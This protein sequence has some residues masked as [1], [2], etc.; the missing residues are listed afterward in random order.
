MP[1]EIIGHMQSYE[2]GKLGKESLV[3]QIMCKNSDFKINDQTPYAE[4]WMGIHNNG[5]SIVKD[6]EQPLSTWLKKYVNAEKSTIEQL[7]PFLFKVLSVNKAL[8]IQCHPNKQQAM[9]LFKKMPTIYKDGNHK[10][11]MTIAVTEFQVMSGFRPVDEI[12]TFLKEIPE[13]EMLFPKGLI[14]NYLN[15]HKEEYMKEI[16]K[17]WLAKKESEMEPIIKS[18]LNR[19]GNKDDDVK[20]KYHFSLIKQLSEWYPNDVGVF[21]PFFLN[22]F[23]L[24][25]GECMFIA[26]G[27]PHAYI[28]G[29][30]VECMACSDNV[31][32]CGLTP[33]LKDV[34][35]LLEILDFKSYTV[36][37]LKM[38]GVPKGTGNVMVFNPPKQEFGLTRVTV[39]NGETYQSSVCKACS[40]FIVLSGVGE[41]GAGKGKKV[42]KF[43][44][45]FFL[46]PN[47]TCSIKCTNEGPMVLYFAYGVK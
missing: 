46:L 14:S 39:Q 42:L 6:K 43:G 38:V 7:L 19:L 40:I 27:V 44:S 17:A 29:D 10:P 13:F 18:F 23:I 41:I 4:L 21:M 31:V 47:E 45:I 2:W 22:Y 33:K 20:E 15:E 24:K 26:A 34:N 30:C 28:K 12:K 36:D 35:V 3:A 5:E 9:D 11:E 8:S 32:R 25:P 16:L 1:M 37:Q